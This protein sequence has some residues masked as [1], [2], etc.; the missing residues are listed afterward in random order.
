MPYGYT[1][2]KAID[3]PV[4][5]YVH[6]TVRS[7]LHVAHGQRA[8]VGE[9]LLARQIIRVVVHTDLVALAQIHLTIARRRS[10]SRMIFKMKPI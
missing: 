6:D 3:V 4:R 10:R 8:Q 7:H 1:P 9:R 5:G 2:F